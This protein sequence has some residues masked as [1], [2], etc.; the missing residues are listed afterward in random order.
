MFA[1]LD[2]GECSDCGFVDCGIA[3][4][5]GWLPN[6]SGE[7]TACKSKVIRTVTLPRRPPSRRIVTSDIYQVVMKYHSSEHCGKLFFV[8]FKTHGR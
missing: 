4:Y 1:G 5:C 8:N 3:L 2:S 6:I 7:Y